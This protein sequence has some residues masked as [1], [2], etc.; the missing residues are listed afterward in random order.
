MSDTEQDFYGDNED[1]KTDRE[2]VGYDGYTKEPLYEGD[3]IVEWKGQKYLKENF[4]Q[5]NL[6]L[7]SKGINDE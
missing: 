1:P 3:D 5:M 7:D 2:I 4:I 6:G